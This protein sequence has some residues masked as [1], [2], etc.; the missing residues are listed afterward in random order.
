MNSKSIALKLRIITIAI[1]LL[2]IFVTVY[3]AFLIYD[4]NT[5]YPTVNKG[6]VLTNSI[7]LDIEEALS[8]ND[9]DNEIESP[10]YYAVIDLSGK[11][12]SSTINDL[13]FRKIIHNE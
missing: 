5:M 7:K 8:K 13:S 10:Y 12:L 1:V 4:K 11:V 3:S 2:A 6:R 9:F